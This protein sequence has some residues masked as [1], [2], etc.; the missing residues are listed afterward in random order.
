M[1]RVA[2]L[3]LV[4]VAGC[5]AAE[6]KEAKSSADA[7][8]QGYPGSAAQTATTPSQPKAEYAPPPPPVQ[9]GQSGQPSPYPTTP[10]LSPEMRIATES[11][12]SSKREIETAGAQCKDA[13]RALGSMD[14]A[15]GRICGME[16]GDRCDDAKQKLYSARD[17]VRSSCGKCDDGT[18]T[19]RN[20]PVPSR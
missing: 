11:L 15:A 16:P 5:A 12:E 8:Q 17:R 6:R 9:P 19:D 7:P 1:K 10:P 14:R 3:L 13:C 2:T 4:V 20:A 18:A